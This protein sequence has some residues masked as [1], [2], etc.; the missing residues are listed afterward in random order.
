MGYRAGIGR[1]DGVGKICRIAARRDQ[2]ACGCDGDCRSHS[3]RLGLLRREPTD[4]SSGRWSRRRLQTHTAPPVARS[5]R[6]TS[7]AG[8]DGLSWV[9]HREMRSA[10]AVGGTG[11]SHPRSRWR[12]RQH[13]T[14]HRHASFITGRRCNSSESSTVP[15]PAVRPSAHRPGPFSVSLAP[16]QYDP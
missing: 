8:E 4:S 14:A 13:R 15:P 6:R 2:S 3:G 9:R 7:T 11:N 1:T 16:L 10:A 12:G 5:I